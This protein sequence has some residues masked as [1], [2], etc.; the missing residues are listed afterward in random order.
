MRPYRLAPTICCLGLLLTLVPHVVFAADLVVFAA[1]SLK[2]ALDE[3]NA[4]YMRQSGDNVK[5]SF[6]A[7]PALARQIESGAPAQLFISA[8]L[9]WMDYLEK[10]NLIQPGTRKNLLGNRLVIA[11]PADA[12]IKLDIK[13]GFDLA[14]ALKGGHLAMADPSS[15]PAGKYGKAALEKLEAWG[16]VESAV[17]RTENVR[18]A[19]LL[20]SR[21]EAPL[22]IVYATDVA[23]D[24]GV[25][26]AGVFPPETHPPIVYPIALTADSRDPAAG[27]LL[28]F[29]TSPAA[30]PIFEKHGFTRSP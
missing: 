24:P 4:A 6:G 27:R 25:K 9:D 12:D 18:G 1:A 21:H 11:A 28:D 29:L 23:A 10:R 3:A 15:V 19:L 20:V 7:S 22:G 5:T 8:D 16:S 26:I 2:E 30:K 13:P 14:G 17:A